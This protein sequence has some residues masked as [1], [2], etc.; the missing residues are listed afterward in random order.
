MLYLCIKINNTEIKNMINENYDLL[1]QYS[2]TLGNGNVIFERKYKNI[3]DYAKN[4]VFAYNYFNSIDC[5]EKEG[6]YQL[7]AKRFKESND[8]EDDGYMCENNSDVCSSDG[9]Q[10]NYNNK[11]FYTIRINTRNE[12]IK[13]NADFKNEGIYKWHFSTDNYKN[14]SLTIK[15]NNSLLNSNG[16]I[17]GI[18]SI[19]IVIIISILLK[20]KNEKI[21]MSF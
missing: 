11:D 14:I 19:V 15:K 2:Y 18:V 6:Y 16:I 8:S 12:I 13:N 17:I 20:I 10:P 3:C 21:K 1:K 4:N 9:I 7:S 5:K